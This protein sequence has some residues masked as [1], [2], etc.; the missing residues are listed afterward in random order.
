M[1]LDLRGVERAEQGFVRSDPPFEAFSEAVIVSYDP[2]KICLVDLINIHLHTHSST[3]QHSM[4]SRYRS[5]IYFFMPE[6]ENDIRNIL[7]NLQN[8][9]SDSLVTLVLPFVESKAA[10]GRYQNYYKKAP[11]KP[12]CKRYIDPKLNKLRTK[13]ARLLKSP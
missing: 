10:H 6:Q 5:A 9:F 8:D 12:F 3:S 13:Y 2:T 4:R 1:F 11:D 7:C